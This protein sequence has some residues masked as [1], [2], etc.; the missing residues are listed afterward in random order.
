M[1]P[2]KRKPTSKILDDSADT[3]EPTLK[4]LKASN[5]TPV[6]RRSTPR[7]TK[8]N[9]SD[10]DWLVTNEK[11]PLANQDL[12]TELSDPKTYENFTRED[13]DDLRLS[14]PSSVPTSSDGY[15][16]PMDFFKYDADF[17]RGIREFQEDLSTGRLDPAWQVAAAQAMEER[18]RG[19]FDAYKENQFEEFWG[20]KQ[21]LDWHAVAGESAKL[22]L[23][24]MIQN[25]IF[26]VGDY[27]SYSRVFGK[28]KNKLMVEKEC[29]VLA[30]YMPRR[31][32]Y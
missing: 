27:F 8:V 31:Y 10:P 16:I 11:S 24:V 29:K 9:R 21:K 28:S 17:R 20:Q 19:E 4:R 18:A 2:R 25:G 6:K 14:L 15:S 22:K 12:Y 1:T 7:A 26:Q 23:D 13:W 32:G 30:L 3:A 5:N